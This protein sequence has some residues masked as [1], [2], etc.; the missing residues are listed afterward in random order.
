MTEKSRGYVSAQQVAELAGVSRSQV[1]RTFTPGASVSHK[2]REKVMAAANALGYHVNYLARGLLNEQ[3][4]I[5]CIVTTDLNT[6]YQ[7]AF[8]DALSTRL[9]QA[10]KVTLVINTRSADTEASEALRQSLYYRADAT[11][12]L[13]GQPSDALI[14][15]CLDNGQ[16]VLVVNREPSLSGVDSLILHNETAAAEACEQLV[17]AG[18]EHLGLVTSSRNTPSL[19][20][21]VNAFKNRAHQMGVELSLYQQGDTSSYQTGL[22]A[23]RQ[24]LTES[25]QIDGVFCVT[26][27]LACGFMDAARHELGRTIPDDLCV[28]GFDNIEQ[29]GWHSYQLTTFAQ[30]LED[31]AEAIVD[32]LTRQSPSAVSFTPSLVRRGTVRG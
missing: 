31:I 2:T 28:I 29:A 11:V 1:S 18:C 3:S 13:S 24:L 25:P 27:L 16:H 21:R 17:I 6:P 30:P 12:I 4:Q 7:G 8:L 15:L 9:Q 22:K 14:K 10:G 5:V 26:D 19:A 20:S 23:A 32:R